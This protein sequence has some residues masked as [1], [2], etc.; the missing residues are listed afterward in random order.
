LDRR[1][2]QV[3]VY[4]NT[5]GYIDHIAILDVT[6]VITTTGSRQITGR[7]QRYNDSACQ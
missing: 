6:S 7:F 1:T 4:D 2:I 3:P 5:T